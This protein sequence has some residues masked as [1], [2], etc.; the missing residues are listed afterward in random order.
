M[1][2]C[3]TCG[4]QL[5]DDPNEVDEIVDCKYCEAIFCSSEC[6]SDHEDQMHAGEALPV[7]EDEEER[8]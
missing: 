3:G 7:G 2:R 1:V 4:K 6:A 8:R 5:P